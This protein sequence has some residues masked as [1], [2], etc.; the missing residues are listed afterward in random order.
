MKNDIEHNNQ[1]ETNRSN[2]NNSINTDR[3]NEDYSL[4]GKIIIMI[5]WFSYWKFDT[6]LKEDGFLTKYKSRKKFL[7]IGFLLW[8]LIIVIAFL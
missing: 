3:S 4:F 7:L 6:T 2:T 8:A 1:D 5:F